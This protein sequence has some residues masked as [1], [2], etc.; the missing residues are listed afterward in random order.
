M[1]TPSEDH[2][3]P[4]VSAKGQ[5]S[6]FKNCYDDPGNIASGY[7]Q[8]KYEPNRSDGLGCYAFSDPRFIIWVI[9]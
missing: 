4:D 5:G 9:L 2:I 7:T 8:L 6:K 3:T 1:T